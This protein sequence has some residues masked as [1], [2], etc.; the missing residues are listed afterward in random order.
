MTTVNLLTWNCSVCFVFFTFLL[1][2]GR[3]CLETQRKKIYIMY[4]SSFAEGHKQISCQEPW[5]GRLLQ[6]P[7]IFTISPEDLRHLIHEWCSSTTTALAKSLT[8][9]ITFFTGL[10]VSVAFCFFSPLS[11]VVADI[12][13]QRGQLCWALWFVGNDKAISS[14]E[15]VRGLEA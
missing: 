4:S 7:L 12:S 9:T 2:H 1:P 5:K 10:L 6:S 14:L 3:D 15:R 11:P 13:R 8:K